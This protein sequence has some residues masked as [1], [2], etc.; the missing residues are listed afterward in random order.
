[1]SRRIGMDGVRLWYM[2]TWKQLKVPHQNLA[3][4]GSVTSMLWITR[5]HDVQEI[6][7]HGTAN[8]YLVIWVHQEVSFRAT[9]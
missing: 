6:L 8:G 1:M 4:R 9:G 7:C 5:T 2:K 3:Q